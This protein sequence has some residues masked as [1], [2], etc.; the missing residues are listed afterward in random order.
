MSLSTERNDECSYAGF[1]LCLAFLLM[2]WAVLVA[3]SSKRDPDGIRL[4]NSGAAPGS[5]FFRIFSNRMA[6]IK[7]L[8]PSQYLDKLYTAKVCGYQPNILIRAF[9]CQLLTS[10]RSVNDQCHN[11]FRG[12]RVSKHSRR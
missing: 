12:F 6:F 8:E 2:W 11:L 7:K 10:R 3:I 5:E 9:F 1:E 4:L